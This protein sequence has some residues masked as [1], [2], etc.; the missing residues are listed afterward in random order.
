MAL[1]GNSVL[2][3]LYFL[4]FLVQKIIWKFVLKRKDRFS[5]IPKAY[6]MIW[7]LRDQ[8]VDIQKKWDLGILEDRMEEFVGEWEIMSILSNDLNIKA[9]ILIPKTT[10]ANMKRLKEIQGNLGLKFVNTLAKAEGET[11]R[12]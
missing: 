6:S 11:I 12:F 10:Q 1:I 5:Q 7:I 3:V 8:E 4:G 2:E 9:K